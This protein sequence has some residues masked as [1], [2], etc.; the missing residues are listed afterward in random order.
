MILQGR[1]TMLVIAWARIVIQKK[2]Q[3]HTHTQPML[4][5]AQYN[6]SGHVAQ[7]VL[8]PLHMYMPQRPTYRVGHCRD[9]HFEKCPN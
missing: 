2:T 7:P 1:T 4:P 3:T 8:V 9:L 5:A 6:P